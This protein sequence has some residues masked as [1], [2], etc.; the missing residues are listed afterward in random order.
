MGLFSRKRKKEP[1]IIP[2]ITPAHEHCW[3]DLPWYMETE[4]NGSLRTASY[5]IIEEY[6]CITCGEV[7]KKVLEE[8]HW[9]NITSKE[10]EETY[11]EI[12]KRYKE[13]LRPKAVVK[14]M[15]NDIQLVQDA[16]KLQLMEKLR[17][18]PHPNAGN[19]K[20]NIPMKTDTVPKIELPNNNYGE[21]I[22]V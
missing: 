19:A 14:D 18:I 5:Q 15:I 3:K 11:S 10:R 1:E 13:Y 22:D 21:L 7:K 16:E 2:I 4:Y 8:E 6:I 17:S 9:S 20:Q 12:R